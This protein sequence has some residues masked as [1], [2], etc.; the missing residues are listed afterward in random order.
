M[1]VLRGIN[2][3]RLYRKKCD[4]INS[5]SETMETL[6]FA[7]LGSS[8]YLRLGRGQ[9]IKRLLAII[10]KNPADKNFEIFN[11]PPPLNTS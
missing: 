6:A 2:S 1:Q 3:G 11:S 9:K 5:F 10:F 8:H 4:D 7:L